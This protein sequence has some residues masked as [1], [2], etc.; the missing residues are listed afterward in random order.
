MKSVLLACMLLILSLPS[1]VTAADQTADGRFDTQCRPPPGRD[2]GLCLVSFSRLMARPEDYDGKKV[3]LT[4]FVIR[5]FGRYVIF[6]SRLSYE[7]I[8]PGEGIELQGDLDVDPGF[9]EDITAGHFP[10]RISGVFDAHYEGPW[11]IRLGALSRV[12]I[13]NYRFIKG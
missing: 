6:P 5:T 1:N 2:E 9:N 11:P 10:V 12:R 3:Q 13:Y 8:I 4:G 7:A